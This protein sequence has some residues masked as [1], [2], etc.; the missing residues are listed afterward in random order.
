V[1]EGTIVLY[2][3]RIENIR[4]RSIEIFK[5]RGTSHSTKIHPFE[6]TENGIVV[7]SKEEVFA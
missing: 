6:I 2:Y 5:M 3:T 4:V 1:V 7:Y